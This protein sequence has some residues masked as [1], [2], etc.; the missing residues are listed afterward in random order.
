MKKEKVLFINN[1]R[2]FYYMKE[3]GIS[4]LIEKI[5]S[6][7]TAVKDAC[8][9]TVPNEKEIDRIYFGNEFCDC[10]IPNLQNVKEV[11]KYCKAKD[12]QFSMVMPYITENEISKVDSIL[13][14][15]SGLHEEIEIVCNDW[16]TV[17]IIT[18][19]YDGLCIV[20]GRLLDKMSKD[21]R[22]SYDDYQKIFDNDSL[23]YITTSNIYAKSYGRFL[24]KYNIRRIELDCPPQ[25]LKLQQEQ[26][27]YNNVNV[28]LYVPFAFITTGRMCMMRFLNQENEKKY[29]LETDCKMSCQRYEQIMKKIRNCQFDRNSKY[30]YDNIQLYRKGNT[31]FYLASNYKDIIALNPE[32]DRIIYQVGIPM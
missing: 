21:V 24:Q 4:G 11:Y 18:E 27:I 10:L 20:V 1:I 23:Q 9:E 30:V 29:S 22:I 19:K 6:F 3:K 25:G 31:V 12:I 7:S 32:I 14:Y 13:K 2:Q 17:Y 26:N 8:F 15:L 16:G 28:S 5:D